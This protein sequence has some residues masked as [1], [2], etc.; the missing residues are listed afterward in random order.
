MIRVAESAFATQPLPTR[1]SRVMAATRSRSVLVKQREEPYSKP[2]IADH[3]DGSGVEIRLEIVAMIEDDGR[4][5]LRSQSF[6]R[7]DQDHRR[8]PTI[9]PAQEALRNRSHPTR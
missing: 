2:I 6:P 7:S 8:R 4:L 1:G 3:D 5:V 9:Q